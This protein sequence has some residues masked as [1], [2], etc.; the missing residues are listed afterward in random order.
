VIGLRTLDEEKELLVKQYIGLLDTIEEAFGHI[1]MSLEKRKQLD[2]VQLWDD[3]SMALM[4]IEES[5]KVLTEFF[6]D[7]PG[8][9]DHFSRFDFV[10]EKAHLLQY[11]EFIAWG[12][13]IGESIQPAFSEW[14][15]SLRQDFRPYSLN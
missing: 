4:Q 13:L 3:V 5:N 12:N 11:A 7:R 10:L 8:V 9:L 2:A 15:S 6:A 14:R 1:L